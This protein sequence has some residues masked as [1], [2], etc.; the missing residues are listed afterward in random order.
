MRCRLMVVPLMALLS[1]AAAMSTG[2]TMDDANTSGL[3][4]VKGVLTRKMK[5]LSLS[6]D[7]DFNFSFINMPYY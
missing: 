5:I 7:M 6:R 1:S 2:K 4:Q 3:V